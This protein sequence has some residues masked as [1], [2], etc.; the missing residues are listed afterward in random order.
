M[1]KIEAYYKL[2]KQFFTNTLRNTF[3]SLKTP[4]PYKLNAISLIYQ[5][6]DISLR[7]EKSEKNKSD[8]L[9][10]KIDDLLFTCVIVCFYIQFS[11]WH[12]RQFFLQCLKFKFR[13]TK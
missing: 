1:S 2:N 12:S 10:I 11:S 4:L 6:E 8:N 9:R 13:A 7:R 3:S 5:V